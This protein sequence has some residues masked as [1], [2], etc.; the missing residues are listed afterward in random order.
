MTFKYAVSKIQFSSSKSFFRNFD[1]NLT[2]FFAIHD[3]LLSGQLVLEII[4]VIVVAIIFDKLLNREN[5]W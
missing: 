5:V 3:D 2:E 1:K 4:L